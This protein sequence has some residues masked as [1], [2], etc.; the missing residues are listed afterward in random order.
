[1]FLPQ[2][3]PT[4]PPALVVAPPAL[5]VAPPAATVSPPAPVLSPPDPFAALPLAVDWLW[6][7]SPTSAA[8]PRPQPARDAT[9]TLYPI[10]L[11]KEVRSMF[12]SPV[13]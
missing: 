13:L 9:V 3:T 5:V 12:G 8:P 1:V 10:K 11:E 6:V 4:E 2:E 7:S